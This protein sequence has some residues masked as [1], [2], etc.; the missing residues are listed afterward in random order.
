MLRR[1]ILEMSTGVGVEA[2]KQGKLKSIIIS[3]EFK[4]NTGPLH[5][6]ICFNTSTDS[7]FNSV[8]FSNSGFFSTV[9]LVRFVAIISSEFPAREFPGIP[10]F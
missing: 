8:S 2:L 5:G 1:Q 3:G 6:F 10:E 7:Q 9:Q 4:K